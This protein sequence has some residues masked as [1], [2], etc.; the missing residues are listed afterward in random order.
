MKNAI[1]RD[2]MPC[3]SCKNQQFGGTY[4]LRHQAD[5]NQWTRNVNSNWQRK[6]SAMKCFESRIVFLCKVLWLLVT[7]NIPSL[8]VLITMMIEA[9]C[10]SEMLVLARVT[11]RT[12]PED[13]IPQGHHHENL[14]SYEESEEWCLL[15]CYAMWLL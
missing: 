3:G 1:F 12:I 13:G 15:R 5:E 4:H 9:I 10:S 14:K 7:A 6:H 2:V 11:Q 8:P